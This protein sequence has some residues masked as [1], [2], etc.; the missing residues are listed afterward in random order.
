MTNTIQDISK[1][2][3]LLRNTTE[4][5]LS[6]YCLV[7]ISNIMHRSSDKEEMASEINDIVLR[8]RVEQDIVDRLRF[9]YGYLVG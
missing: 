3:M 9:R 5:K 8:S 1:R 7:L 6:R 2:A 4:R